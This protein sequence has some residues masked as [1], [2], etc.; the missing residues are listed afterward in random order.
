ME[1]ALENLTRSWS[2]AL[3]PRNSPLLLNFSPSPL[4]LLLLL[5]LSRPPGSADHRRQRCQ[6]RGWGVGGGEFGGLAG[7]AAGWPGRGGVQH[8]PLCGS[9]LGPGEALAK[10]LRQ[11]SGAP[12]GDW[13]LSAPTQPPRCHLFDGAPEP[14]PKRVPRF[15]ACGQ[16]VEGSWRA[17]SLKQH[18]P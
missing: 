2:S 1:V 10:P 18:K 9:A 13:K 17:K 6:R 5:L 4:L 11:G 16:H 8:L 7:A 15:P 12:G 14:A 3:G